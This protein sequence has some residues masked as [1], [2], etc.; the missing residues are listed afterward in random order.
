[1]TTYAD[2]IARGLTRVYNQNSIDEEVEL[3]DMRMAVVSDL[4]KGQ[5]DRADDFQICE[6]TYRAAA[7]HYWLEEFELLLLGDIE[8][9]WECRP[10][11]VIREYEDVLLSEQRFADASPARRYKRFVGNHDDLWYY[12]DEVRKHLAPYIDGNPVIEGLRLKVRDQGD[13]LGELFLV[14]GHQGTLESDRFA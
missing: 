4:H 13:L 11:P 10:N 1:M 2:E 6:H 5:R 8:E 9:L 7:D 3:T 12:P 14:H